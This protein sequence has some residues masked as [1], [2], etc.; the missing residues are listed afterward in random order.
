M[1]RDNIEDAIAFHERSCQLMRAMSELPRYTAHDDA[2]GTPTSPLNLSQ[3]EKSQFEVAAVTDTQWTS[4]ATRRREYAS[5][6]RQ[7]SRVRRLMRKLLPSCMSATNPAKFYD[8][9]DESDAGSVRR[10]RLKLDE[11][12][13]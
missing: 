8:A 7:N 9:E 3:P 12:K 5:I 1:P 13:F 6:D 11:E 2:A 10:Y 4:D